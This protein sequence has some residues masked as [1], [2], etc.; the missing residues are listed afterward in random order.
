MEKTRT[1]TINGDL[2][3]LLK[4]AGTG[5]IVL[6][7]EG[8]WYS[9]DSHP[10]GVV[11]RLGDRFLLNGETLLYEGNWYSWDSHPQGVVIGLDNKLL[12]NG[13]TLL[14]EGDQDDWRSHDK[15]VVIRQGNRFLLV[16]YKARGTSYQRPS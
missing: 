12:L 9:W 6:I 11:I 15:G 5:D 10:Q 1:I 14:Y 4:R 3:E 13:E 2:Q 8:N 16:I 7:C